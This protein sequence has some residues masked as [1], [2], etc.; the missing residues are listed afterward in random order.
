MQAPEAPFGRSPEPKRMALAPAHT[1]PVLKALT[2]DQISS[3]LQALQS[4]YEQDR[5]LWGNIHDVTI[6]HADHLKK[7]M[8]TVHEKHVGL[9]R[10]IDDGKDRTKET[11]RE[12]NEEFEGHVNKVKE[13]FEARKAEAAASSETPASASKAYETQQ[14]NLAELS[15][16]TNNCLLELE[17]SLKKLEDVQG[18]VRQES[19][20]ALTSTVVVLES[21]LAGEFATVRERVQQIETRQA[22]AAGSGSGAGP[23]GADPIFQADASGAAGFWTQGH[24]AQA[25]GAS[26][27]QSM[28]V[29]PSQRTTFHSMDPE[30]AGQ[31]QKTVFEEKTTQMQSN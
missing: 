26:A 28:G 5:K 29:G 11:F 8:E 19:I 24:A 22:A 1:E 23:R 18:L 25:A 16:R 10:Y 27:G 12:V 20:D 17:G 15:S 2:A 7:I 30:E 14:T 3:Q 21:K 4:M 13:E 6:D 31:D 9:V